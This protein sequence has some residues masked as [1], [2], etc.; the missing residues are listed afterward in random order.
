MTDEHKDKEKAEAV[1][2]ENQKE[3]NGNLAMHAASALALEHW[4]FFHT[5]DSEAVV[6]AERDGHEESFSVQSM[7]FK[8]MLRKLAYIQ[9]GKALSKSDIAKIREELETYA[10]FEA[11]EDE[12]HTRLAMKDGRIYLDLANAKWEQVEIS[13]DGWKVIQA[14]ESP[15]KFRRGSSTKP[16]PHPVQEEGALDK[17][18][19]FLRTDSEEA[20]VLMVSWLVAAFR[21]SGPF[22]ILLLQGEKGSAKSTTAR[23][24]QDLIDPG[25]PGSFP[26]NERSLGIAGSKS[27]VLSVDNVSNLPAWLSDAFCRVSTGFGFRTRKLRTDDTEVKFEFA[28]P[29]ILNGITNIATRD[30]LADRCITITL[31]LLSKKRRMSESKLRREWDQEKPAIL[32]AL[33]NALAEALRNIDQVELETTPR[34]ADF[35][36]WAVAAEPALGWGQGTFMRVYRENR[37]RLVDIALESE[38]VAEAVMQFMKQKARWQGTPTELLRLLDEMVSPR[39]RQQKEWPKLANQLSGKLRRMADS[40]RKR[41]VGFERQHSG[42]RLIIL[43]RM[44]EESREPEKADPGRLTR[45]I[46]ET[47]AAQAESVRSVYGSLLQEDRSEETGEPETSYEEGAL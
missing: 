44:V 14:S 10:L 6:I 37:E 24:L 12:L 26:R 29:L 19:D 11:P 9:M 18:K 1:K 35:A 32:G 39:V 17:L 30:D 31:P 36:E 2:D 7:H 3:P 22:P 21:P 23:L 47:F 15:V 34:M 46:A 27:W 20:W 13:R 38:P 33:L 25:V 42:N 5:P 28:R 43:T 8:L 4:G 41:G 16:L 40:L 45:H